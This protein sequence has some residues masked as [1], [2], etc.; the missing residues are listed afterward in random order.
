MLHTIIC[1]IL[2]VAPIHAD[3]MSVMNGDVIHIVFDTPEE[4]ENR[5][6][7]IL[8]VS[9]YVDQLAGLTILS[10]SSPCGQVQVQL[11][12]LDDGTYISTFVIGTGSVMIPFSCSVGLWKMTVSLSDGTDYVGRFLVL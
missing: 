11:Q 3:N 12:N 8:P 5:G 2:A 1:A 9:G 10:F 6:P 4:Q 7:A